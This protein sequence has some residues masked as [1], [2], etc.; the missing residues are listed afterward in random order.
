MLQ[1]I[2][3]LGEYASSDKVLIVSPEALYEN[4]FGLDE[5]ITI[6]KFGPQAT[7]LSGQ[8]ASIFGMPIVVSRFMSADLAATGKYTGSGSTTGMLVVSRESWNIF[9]RRGIQIAQEQDITSGAY[10]MVATERLTFDSLDASTVKNVAFG[11]N[12]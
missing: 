4:L 2:A 1:L 7:I 12:L 5:V 6:D 10:N 11:F 3:Q 9:A 8:L